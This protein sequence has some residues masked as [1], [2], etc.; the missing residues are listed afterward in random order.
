[1]QRV[2]YSSTSMRN[3]RATIKTKNGSPK[4][5]K[6]RKRKNKHIE[7]RPNYWRLDYTSLSLSIKRKYNTC[8]ILSIEDDIII[9]PQI[10]IQLNHIGIQE[11]KIS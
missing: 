5:E 1:M 6:K 3:K 8:D 4:I 9:Q 11:L 10:R 2:T 7:L